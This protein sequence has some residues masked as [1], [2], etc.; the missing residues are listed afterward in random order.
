MKRDL[1]PCFYNSL[2]ECSGPHFFIEKT[3][4]SLYNELLITYESDI[5]SGASLPLMISEIYAKND[6]K[7]FPIK[8]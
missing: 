3:T 1:N 7:F 6:S 5:F 2:T 8:K 4:C